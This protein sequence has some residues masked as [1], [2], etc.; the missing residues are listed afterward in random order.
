MFRYLIE[1]RME[2]KLDRARA[3]S[4]HL[5]RLG[6]GQL[7]VAV[8]GNKLSLQFR[9][10][11]AELWGTSVGSGLGKMALLVVPVWAA[12]QVSENWYTPVLVVI[13]IYLLALAVW[14]MAAHFE[15]DSYKLEDRYTDPK[16]TGVLKTLDSSVHMSVE[17]LQQGK[18]HGTALRSLEAAVKD[19]KRYDRRLPIHRL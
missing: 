3:L 12:I 8:F 14:V 4:R 16:F 11:A 13:V 19:A 17:A 15:R 2:L 10:F 18:N 9:A 6:E 5:H 7:D 1:R